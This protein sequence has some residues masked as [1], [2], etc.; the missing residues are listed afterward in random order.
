MTYVITEASA[1]NFCTAPSS[2]NILTATFS[3]RNIPN[4]TSP[5]SPLPILSRSCKSASGITQPLSMKSLEL[6]Q[7]SCLPCLGKHLMS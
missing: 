5:N 3:L 4:I 7:Y 1:K 2:F 6:M